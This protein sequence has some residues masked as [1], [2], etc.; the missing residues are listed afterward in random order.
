[1][2]LGF[3]RPLNPGRKPSSEVRDQAGDLFTNRL[4][5]PCQQA[6]VVVGR[7]ATASA[8]RVSIRTTDPLFAR[9][10]PPP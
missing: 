4:G 6:R 1:M 3:L 5:L 7:V 10:P 2:P 8:T 9:Y